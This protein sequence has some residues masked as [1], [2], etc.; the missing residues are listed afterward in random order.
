MRA[1]IVIVGSSEADHC[2]QAGQPETG[3]AARDEL[4]FE[5]HG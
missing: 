3:L 4:V 1:Q 5:E 2:T